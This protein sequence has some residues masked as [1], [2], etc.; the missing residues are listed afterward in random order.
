MLI[1]LMNLFGCAAEVPRDFTRAEPPSE[2]PDEDGLSLIPYQEMAVSV[3]SEVNE[4]PIPGATLELWVNQ[5]SRHLLDEASSSSDGLASLHFAASWPASDLS[6][7]VT[8]PEYL[9]AEIS[10][11]ELESWASAPDTVLDVWMA[12]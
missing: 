5:D 7:L 12:P 2:E 3:C 9:E 6:L 1:V 4:E 10:A 11:A 8:H